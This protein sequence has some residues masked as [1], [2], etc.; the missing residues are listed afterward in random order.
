MRETPKYR[1]KELIY[2]RYF[3]RE[4]RASEVE[5]LASKMNI[6]PQ[7]LRKVWAYPKGSPNEALPSQLQVIATEYHLRIEDLLN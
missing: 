5:R 3:T 2:S 1:I 4:E 7:H 6:S